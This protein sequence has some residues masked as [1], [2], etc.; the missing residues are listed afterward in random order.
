MGFT[1]DQEGTRGQ[2]AMNLV[3]HF[4]CILHLQY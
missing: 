2:G 1:G 3:V 4:M